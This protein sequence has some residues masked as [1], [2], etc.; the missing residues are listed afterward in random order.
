MQKSN[1]P[2]IPLSI[3]PTN[4]TNLPVNH[5]FIQFAQKSTHGIHAVKNVT[6]I[7]HLTI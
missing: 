4:P 2:I 3:H 7:Q 1:H 5:Q 6:T